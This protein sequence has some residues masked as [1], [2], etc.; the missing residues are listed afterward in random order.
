MGYRLVENRRQR[1]SAL[2]ELQMLYV[3]PR[4]AA[5]TAMILL[6]MYVCTTGMQGTCWSTRK[7]E[8]LADWI[9]TSDHTAICALRT[10]STVST[11]GYLVTRHM[12]LHAPKMEK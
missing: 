7:S 6:T 10:R 12:Y 5:R 4:H 3:V 2:R 8:V 1:R 11:D 9:L